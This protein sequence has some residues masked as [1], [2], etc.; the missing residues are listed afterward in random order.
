MPDD[1]ESLNNTITNALIETAQETIPAQKNKT[2]NWLTETT[3]QAITNKHKIRK[4]HGASSPQYRVA[5]T[6]I[7]KLVKKDKLKTIEEECD[8][9]SNIPPDK[10]FFAAV[11]KLKRKKKTLG[12]GYEKGRWVSCH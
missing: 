5:K 10:Q 4:Q 1:V 9:L 11:K 3:K 8:K 2:P 12:M 7:K 6:E